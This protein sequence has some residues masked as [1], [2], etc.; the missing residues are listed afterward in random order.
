MDFA[1]EAVVELIAPPPRNGARADA[2]DDDAFAQHLEAAERC[3]PAPTP[4][5]KTDRCANETESP[6]KSDRCATDDDAAATPKDAEPAPAEGAPRCADAPAETP[7]QQPASPPTLL[8]LSSVLF[9][10]MNHQAQAETQAPAAAPIRD[11]INAAPLLSHAPA[12]D[13]AEGEPRSCATDV[14]APG[15]SAA[16]TPVRPNGREAAPSAAAPAATAAPAAEA[17]TPTASAP[18]EADAAAAPTATQQAQTAAAAAA[19]A[20]AA[21]ADA[22]TPPRPGRSEAARGEAKA[23][24]KSH[25]AA[26]AASDNAATKPQA[27]SAPIISADGAAFTLVDAPDTLAA[28]QQA[29]ASALSFSTTHSAQAQHAVLDQAAARAAPASAQVAREIVRRFDGENTRFEVRLDPPELGR[30]EVRLEVSRDHRVTAVVAADSPQ[31]L[32]ELAR[33]ARE[34]EQSLQSAGLELADNG[35]SFDL[36][37]SSDDAGPSDR[38][39]QRGDGARGGDDSAEA[40]APAPA[41][42]IGLERWRGVRV[43]MTV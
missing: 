36:R 20:H 15:K 32:T 8:G 10:L 13:A 3:A 16:A 1:A 34:L 17:A 18:V 24:T 27:R 31:A 25:G 40:P 12:A 14:A 33:H 4:P 11:V 37:Q 41:R 7:K 21:P 43:D 22:R 23:E 29:N 39:T 2:P 6:V 26:Q 5:E 9:A 19:P 28:Q 42:P 38:Q 35:L 30:V